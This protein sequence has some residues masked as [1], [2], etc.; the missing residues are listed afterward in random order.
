MISERQR[1]QL[2]EARSIYEALDETERQVVEALT[3]IADDCR[4]VPPELDERLRLICARVFPL[5]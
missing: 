4:E 5:T 3:E 2:A 1:G